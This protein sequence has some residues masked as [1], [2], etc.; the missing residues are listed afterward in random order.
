[1]SFDGRSSEMATVDVLVVGAGPVGITAATALAEKGVH[2]RIVDSNLAPV[3]LTKA[4]GTQA[5]TLEQL[6]ERV[7]AAMQ[8][9]SVTALMARV[10]ENTD[11]GKA[12]VLS[13]DMRGRT[14]T[15][16][17]VLAQEQWRTEKVLSEYFETLPG[18]RGRMKIERGTKLVSF[19][20]D[21]LGVTCE[22]D[23]PAGKQMLACGWLLAADGGRSTI[24]KALGLSFDGE[25]MDENFLALHA[26][27]DGLGECCWSD[28]IHTTEVGLSK[29][30]GMAPGLFFSMP[31]PE[32]S[33]RAQLL[34]VDLD[35]AQSASFLT[36][37]ADSHGRPLLRPPRDD[38][39]AEIARVRGFGT[40]ELR[41]VPGSVKWCTGFKVNS[42][43]VEHYRSDRVFLCGDACHCHS[44]LGG[45]GMN[46]GMQDA[47]N[48]AW[49]L[50]M[51]VR[52]QARIDG[53]LLDTYE[54]ERRGTD[55]RICRAIE[56]AAHGAASRNPLV[57]FIRGSL[58]RL[59]GMLPALHGTA[60]RAVAMQIHSYRD[61]A[62]SREH[63]ER[64]PAFPPLPVSR[65][66]PA[67]GYRR[68]Q[69]LYRWV[70][71]RIRAGDRLPNFD[72]PGAQQGLPARRLYPYNH[73]WMLL[74][75]EGYAHE[76]ADLARNLS[77][78][79]ILSAAE[80]NALGKEIKSYSRGV[81]ET[82]VTL[83]ASHPALE[84]LGVQAQ[85]LML[86]RPDS[87]V[88]LRS[89]P[90]RLGSVLRYLE[91]AVGVKG[92]SWDR[93]GCPPSSPRFDYLPVV[94]WASVA[95][96]AVAIQLR[97]WPR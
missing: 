27:F 81:I 97:R 73:G 37:E 82:V 74:L 8:A 35:E 50:A 66:F 30:S 25:T 65:I 42:R 61:C 39:V 49:K 78:V 60:V 89:E 26:T 43:L 87:H 20:A 38:E 93:A 71:H 85:C 10:W 23:T 51:V 88:A 91:S 21:D 11:Q 94:V 64:P 45:Q 44:P 3:I 80:L 84:V 34:I 86:V 13:I 76:N 47:L 18:V 55:E 9:G 68:R 92:L 56:R 57:F 77:S 12:A 48:L 36:G 32:D 16:E 6:P 59:A 29:G 54:A 83:P 67:G 95:A 90:A 31:M 40:S 79:K 63:W 41:V 7:V 19:E 69:N 17:G 46:M 75:C 5:R 33:P 24:R 22:L 58:Q 62:L 72:L 53:P 28:G 14:D 2:V 4:S 70:G 52:G 1:M 15:F 96:A